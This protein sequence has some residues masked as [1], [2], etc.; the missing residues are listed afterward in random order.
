MPLLFLIY[1]VFYSYKPYANSYSN[2][3]MYRGSVMSAHSQSRA[4]H[5][6][7]GRYIAVREHQMLFPSQSTATTGSALSNIR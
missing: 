2:H 5:T 4:I 7:I 3:V 6:P 1:S